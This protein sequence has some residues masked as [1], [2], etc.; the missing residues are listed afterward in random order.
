MT[1]GWFMFGW[2][3]V[4]LPMIIVSVWF[5]SGRDMGPADMLGA[6]FISSAA[7]GLVSFALWFGGLVAW[8]WVWG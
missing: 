7:I 1:P 6:G 8:A 2:A 4:A 3:C 5:I